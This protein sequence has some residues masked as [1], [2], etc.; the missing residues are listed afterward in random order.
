MKKTL[1]AIFVILF[2]I[3]LFVS[4][5]CQSEGDKTITFTGTVTW[6]ELEGGFFGLIADDGTRY[7]PRNLPEEYQENGIKV[8]VRA[9]LC[10]EC[11]SIHMWGT[12]IDILSITTL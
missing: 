9:R 3:T 1:V 5:S 2:A 12:I 8:R 10:E 7:E 11:A 4:S 6:V